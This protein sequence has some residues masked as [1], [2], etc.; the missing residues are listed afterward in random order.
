VSP[1][2]FLV[3]LASP[4]SG[5]TFPPERRGDAVATLCVDVAEGSGPPVVDYTLT[6]QGGP[7]LEV[8]A[9]ELT[10]PTGAWTVRRSSAWAS[11]HGRVSWT[12]FI[13]LEQVKPGLV[14]LPDVR[15]SFRDGPS[16]ARE[17]AEWIDILKNVRELPGPG[18]APAAAGRRS[19]ALILGAVAAGACCAVFLAVMFLRR[20][21]SEPPLS[22][23]QRALR[24][25]SQLMA[26]AGTPQRHYEQLA[27]LLRRYT[28]EVYGL[29]ALRQTTGEFLRDAC[30][31]PAL[32]GESAVLRELLERCDLAKF[33]G[34]PAE[35]DEWQRSAE[36]ARQ[37]IQRTARPFEKNGYPSRVN[38]AEE[39]PPRR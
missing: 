8:D 38:S 17:Q 35:P 22:A 5:Y 26:S 9:P 18:P 39:A 11:A 14:P 1:W 33:A 21:R 6:V 31:V 27:D 7:D 23:D 4:E 37:F 29:P 28:A 36:Q 20:R 25:L 19:V 15:L 12:E 34:L 3:M 10:D 16:A 24:A 30:E 2:L 13:E 32:V